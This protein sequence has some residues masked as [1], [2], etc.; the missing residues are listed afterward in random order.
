M[1]ILPSYHEGM[2]LVI[3]EGMCQGCALIS[4]KVGSTPEILDENNVIWVGVK[5]SG[6]LERAIRKLYESPDILI[7][8]QQANKASSYNYTIERNI[9]KLCMICSE[10]EE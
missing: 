9:N 6:D 10:V 1:L 4:T 2:P 7:N 5:S 3:L 8:M